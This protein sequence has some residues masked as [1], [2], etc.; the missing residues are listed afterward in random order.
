MSLSQTFLREL[1]GQRKVKVRNNSKGT[2]FLPLFT[3][4]V[5]KVEI[6]GDH[7]TLKR[8]PLFEKQVEKEKT[9]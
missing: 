6:P 4:E 1:K 3:G 5:K 7:T 9:H 2:N 8:F